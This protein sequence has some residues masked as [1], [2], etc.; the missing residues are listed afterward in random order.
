[1]R[2]LPF[3]FSCTFR[4]YTYV[5][6]PID[7]LL[8]GDSVNSGRCYGTPATYTYA[9]IDQRGYATRFLATARQTRA[10]GKLSQQ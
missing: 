4:H 3:F 7:P 6:W 1:M 9:T 10:R 2:E 8:R 5:L